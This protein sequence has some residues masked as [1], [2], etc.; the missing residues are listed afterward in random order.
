MPS[1]GRLSRSNT[2]A[3]PVS[4]FIKDQS[5]NMKR[6]KSSVPSLK[7]LA[8][9][10]RRKQSVDVPAL[11]TEQ[12]INLSSLPTELQLH[13]LQHL[14]FSDLCA[15]RA[16]SRSSNVLI[17]GPDSAVA[18][19]WITSRLHHVHHLYPPSSENHWKYLT[20]QMRRW[21]IARHLAETIAY[22]IQYKTLL[23]VHRHSASAILS[24]PILAALL[25]P[26]LYTERNKFVI[27]PIWNRHE[28]G[29]V[30]V[31]V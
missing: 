26:V 11:H 7:V 28:G 30:V 18:K 14:S 2:Q 4:P 6:R 17:T 3:T 25:I 9:R 16:T 22:H 12:L 10:S 13:I 24:T 1:L 20:S 23:N 5:A 27:I 8:F 31:I 21:N 19:Y 29:V 15:L